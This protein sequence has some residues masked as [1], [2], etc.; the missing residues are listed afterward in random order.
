MAAL[1][2]CATAATAHARTE[3]QQTQ[4]NDHLSRASDASQGIA[5]DG[6]TII[7]KDGLLLEG[8]DWC[9]EPGVREEALV[10][11][12]AYPGGNLGRRQAAGRA[13]RWVRVNV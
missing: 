4:I 8:G 7:A 9:R 6:A 3:V 13:A 11:A 5:T 2:L 12:V 10:P 1:V